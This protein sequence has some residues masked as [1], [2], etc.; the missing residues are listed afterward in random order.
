MQDEREVAERLG[1][2]LDDVEPRP[3]PLAAAIGQGRGIRRRR[4]ITAAAGIAVI[5]AGAAMIPAV[6]HSIGAPPPP[7]APRHRHYTVTVNQ[8]PAQARHGVIASGTQDGHR[9]QIVMSGTA[10]SWIEAA[11]GATTNAGPA[12]VGTDSQPDITS[13]T[14][15]ST[16]TVLLGGVGPAVTDVRLV[17]TDGEILDL[18]PVAWSGHRWIAIELPAAARLARGIVFAGG[19]ELSYSVPTPGG[20]NLANWWR[21]GQVGPARYSRLIPAGR[22]G[23]RAWVVKADFGP[24]GYC[25]VGT[26]SNW[27]GQYPL[28]PQ[29]RAVIGPLTC[30]N[31]L[32]PAGAADGGLAAASSEARQIRVTLSGGGTKVYAT[33]DVDGIQM[34]AF[35]IPKGQHITSATAYDAAGQIIGTAG[36]R[37][38]SC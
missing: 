26:G 27:C 10:S 12:P 24:W 30:G 34:F 13:M 15:G 2:L 36:A 6:L 20:V 9:W 17:L 28:Q 18:A 4:R 23:G 16:P 33:V 22:F 29:S 38:M 37:T 5:A 8:L 7:A 25:F 21:P 35:I 1:S 31:S 32:I 14:G 19:R 11:T 3:A